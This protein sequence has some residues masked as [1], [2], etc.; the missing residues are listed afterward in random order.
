MLL[1]ILLVLITDRHTD[2]QRLK[3]SLK[4]GHHLMRSVPVN[5]HTSNIQGKIHTVMYIWSLQLILLKVSTQ[6]AVS[7]VSSTG[8]SGNNSSRCS[9][10]MCR[11]KRTIQKQEKKACW[12][13]NQETNIHPMYELSLHIVCIKRNTKMALPRIDLLPEMSLLCG[14]CISFGSSS[15]WQHTRM[16]LRNSNLMMINIQPPDLSNKRNKKPFPGN[17]P[18]LSMSPLLL[19]KPA[20]ALNAK[21]TVTR[22]GTWHI[23]YISRALLPHQCVWF[24]TTWLPRLRWLQL[25]DTWTTSC[26]SHTTVN[27]HLAFMDLKIYRF[28]AICCYQSNATSFL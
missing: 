24:Q 18:C 21:I 15:A 16:L 14:C 17:K 8:V 20:C 7:H 11:S 23:H 9:F 28:A 26:E 6:H 13:T 1:Y 4:V 27:F 12:G 25:L 2:S 5:R 19:L 3:D 22:P 10:A